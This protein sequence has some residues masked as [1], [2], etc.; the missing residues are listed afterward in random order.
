MYHRTHPFTSNPGGVRV[1]HPRVMALTGFF[2]LGILA[3]FGIDAKEDDRTEVAKEPAKV[4][5]SV[6]ELRDG[7]KISA[8]KFWG[9]IDDTGG[10]MRVTDSGRKIAKDQFANRADVLKELIGRIP[11]YTAVVERSVHRGDMTVTAAQ[12]FFRRRV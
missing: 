6:F 1:G 9:F 8:Y 11:S 12:A 2:M 3:P 7:R 5:I 4:E 10:K